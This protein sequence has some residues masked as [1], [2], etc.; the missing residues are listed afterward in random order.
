MGSTHEQCVNV[1]LVFFEARRLWVHMQKQGLNL[2]GDDGG[3]A[4]FLALAAA[5]AAAELAAAQEPLVDTQQSQPFFFL[6]LP[7]FS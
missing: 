4:I 6:S 7:D 3:C 2:G 5:A 1:F